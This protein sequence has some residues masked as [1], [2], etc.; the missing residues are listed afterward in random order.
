M[1]PGS[2][3]D[4]QNFSLSCCPFPGGILIHT[5]SWSREKNDPAKQHEKLRG[6]GQGARGRPRG[7]REVTCSQVARQLVISF[8]R[9]SPPGAVAC[10]RQTHRPHVRCTCQGRKLLLSGKLSVV[11]PLFPRV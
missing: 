11:V 8:R 2:E 5:R 7:I 9:P 6:A 4:P 10:V 1:S 3:L